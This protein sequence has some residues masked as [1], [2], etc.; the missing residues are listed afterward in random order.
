MKR[1]I[2]LLLV[3]FASQHIEG[4]DF[5]QYR[6]QV[7]RH[8]KDHRQG[9]LNRYA[10][11]IEQSWQRFQAFKGERRN[12][13][14]VP[15]PSLPPTLPQSSP[16]PNTPVRLPTPDAPQPLPKEKSQPP[17]PTMPSMPTVPPAAP[18]PQQRF[19]FYGDTLQCRQMSPILLTGTDEK[20]VAKVWRRYHNTKE[21]SL[22]AQALLH[23]ANERGLNDW[24]T[25]EMV[26]T[27]VETLLSSPSVAAD[28]I[29][30][31]QFLLTQMG[32][33]VRIAR[34]DRQLLLL[35]PVKET[36]YDQPY[37]E[38]NAQR[39]YL[40]KDRLCPIDEAEA[41]YFTYTLPEG[42]NAGHIT[43]LL[44]NGERTLKLHTGFTHYCTID[45]GRLRVSL[46]FD[47][48]ALEALRHYPPMDVSNYARSAVLPELHALLWTEL[49]SQL[50][51]MTQRE[52][53]MA[54]MH[55]AQYAFSYATD[56]NQHGYEKPY[57][58][59]ENFYYPQNDC[60][61]RAV[62]LVNAVRELLGL[63]SHLVQYPGHECTAIHFT[64]PTIT[65]DGYLYKGELFI[66]CDPTYIGASIGQ[67]M[68]T[69]QQVQPLIQLWEENE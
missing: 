45:D 2:L 3:C 40:F 15:K 37:L 7:I 1:L 24:L 68:P 35:V 52:A 57:F 54:L 19:I 48:A 60:E 56:G 11:F 13:D 27:Y 21:G 9:V 33:D 67:C 63:R 18:V 39:F 12:N 38:M 8:Y 32:Y 14:S 46:S 62:F 23:V 20:E 16:L 61:D 5:Q 44:F 58:I 17:L 65:G 29:V 47:K 42:T 59:E 34:T 4:Q 6:Q 25:I 26:R 55:F 30:I 53:V 49:K 10:D 50:E 31:E 36:F 43:S 51:G 28:R 22:T 64:D 69:Y 66:I 41:H